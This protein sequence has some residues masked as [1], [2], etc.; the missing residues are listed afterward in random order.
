M[1]ARTLKLL[2]AL[3]A[4]HRFGNHHFRELHHFGVKG[5]I[6]AH[7]SYCQKTESFRA[8]SRNNVVRDRLQIVLDALEKGESME[9]AILMAKRRTFS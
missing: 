6:G 4:K 7:R 3:E 5:S 9:N 1:P 2:S 8:N